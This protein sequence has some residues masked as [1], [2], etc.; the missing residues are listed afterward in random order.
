MFPSHDP[1]GNKRNGNGRYRQKKFGYEGGFKASGY[2]LSLQAN[3]KANYAL[4]QLNSEKK[5]V[6]VTATPNSAGGGSVTLLNPLSRGTDVN[7]RIGQTV[8]FTGLS[9][10][11]AFANTHAETIWLRYLLVKDA[12]PNGVVAS[13]SDIL[14]GTNVQDFRNLDYTG[15]FKILEDKVL[16]LAYADGTVG[17]PGSGFNAVHVDLEQMTKNAKKDKDKNETNYGLGNAGTIADISQNAYYLVL[18]ASAAT[19]NVTF[20]MQSRM[21]YVDN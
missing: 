5:S 16:T 2:G 10:R 19:N 8:R 12:A 11:F 4:S 13:V 3:A 17:Y 6:R 21:R 9:M 7:Q 15:R 20:S 1:R 18:L 14:T